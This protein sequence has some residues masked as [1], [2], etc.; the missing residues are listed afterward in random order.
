MP[1]NQHVS[2]IICAAGKGVRAGFEKNKLL[3]SMP[4]NTGGTVLEHTVHAFVAAGVGQIVVAAAERDKKEIERLLSPFPLCTVVTGGETRTRSVKN[5]LSAVT[6]EIVLVHDGAR[7]YVSGKI[8]ADCITSV[9]TYGSGI[10]ALPLTDTAVRAKEGFIADVPPREEMFAVQTPQGFRT[11]ELRAAYE[12]V[13]AESYTDDSA[14][15]AKFVRPPRLFIGEKENRKLTFAEDF[16]PAHMPPYV[17]TADSTERADVPALLFPQA[18]AVGNGR[19]GIGVDTHAFGKPQD[20]IVL[21]GIKIPAESGL[22]AHSD[23]DVLAHAVTD[24]ILSAAGLRDIGYYFPDTDEKW[25]GA[26]SME[27]LRAALE[28]VKKA[29]FVPCNVSVAVQA[30]KPRLSKFIPTMSGNLAKVMELPLSAVGIAAGT[31]E[32]LGFVG[33]GRGITV[34]AAVLLQKAERG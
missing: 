27:M 20:Y 21:A 13:G 4:G 19:V 22:F 34:T 26:D 10:C 32:G 8:I 5:A 14:V 17:R 1:V 18:Q 30:Q 25:E 12:K 11:A 15:C 3:R 6:G 33:E 24:A 29:G 7:P 16:L 31:N 23:G 28:K 2:V 9:E